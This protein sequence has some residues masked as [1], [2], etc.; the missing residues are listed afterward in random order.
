MISLLLWSNAITSTNCSE[1]SPAKHESL[2]PFAYFL[3]ERAA[4]C[5][6]SSPRSATVLILLQVPAPASRDCPIMATAIE[7]ETFH[8][9]H[10]AAEKGTV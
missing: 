5:S 2:W 8:S 10:S 7:A 1:L 6:E 9:V 3:N 4:D